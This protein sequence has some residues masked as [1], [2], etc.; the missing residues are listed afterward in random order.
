MAM[1][2][3]FVMMATPKSL[4]THA[5]LE[6]HQPRSCSHVA[7]VLA[8]DEQCSSA[9]GCR[10]TSTKRRAAR[11]RSRRRSRIT[12]ADLNPNNVLLKQDMSAAAGVIPK[13]ADFGLSVLMPKEASHV[14]NLCQ[15]TPF[16]TS[17]EVALQVGGGAGWPLAELLVVASRRRG[18]RA[19]AGSG[20]T[21][22]RTHSRELYAR[23][24]ALLAPQRLLSKCILPPRRPALWC[25][26]ASLLCVLLLRARAA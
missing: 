24:A 4:H 20:R 19:E 1:F 10:I 6:A 13:V 8:M 3:L 7:H 15:G 26:C 2:K 22:T 21:H 9:F 14:S 16:Y 12:I 5:L 18:K 25:L 11:C 23:P 17:P